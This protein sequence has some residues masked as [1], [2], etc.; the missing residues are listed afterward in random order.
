MAIPNPLAALNAINPSLVGYTGGYGK[1]L[2]ALGGSMDSMGQTKLDL[3]KQKEDERIRNAQLSLLQNADVR[4]QDAVKQG[5][6]DK[7]AVKQ[8]KFDSNVANNSYLYGAMGKEIP[9]E[10]TNERA[11][12]G[13]MD[14]EIIA[15]TIKANGKEYKG[16]YNGSDG[17]RYV[18][19]SDGTSSPMTG[20]AKPFIEKATVLDTQ[21]VNGKPTRVMTDMFAGKQNEVILPGMTDTT[22][23]QINGA[24]LA[25]SNT[26]AGQGNAARI[27]L[28][29]Q[30]KIA[31]AK[32]E[33]EVENTFS[34]LASNGFTEE[35]SPGQAAYYVKHTPDGSV[36]NIQSVKI[37]GVEKYFTKP[38][39]YFTR[40]S[41]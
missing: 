33:Q 36:P 3:A 29:F 17:N 37:N 41:R 39:N 10:L 34:T 32:N 1:A 28:E 4:A 16:T 31:N 22:Y 6:A 9:G 18:E 5:I 11:Q 21:Y 8:D 7:A 40:P 27:N 2:Q 23:N 13:L 14:P 24:K 25:L 12:L 15:K 20:G 26:F 35:L 19:W 38:K 30:P